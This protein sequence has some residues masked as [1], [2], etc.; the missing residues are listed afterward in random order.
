MK[1]ED[2]IDRLARDATAVR[3]LPRP[4]KRALG[5]LL[6]ALV[7][8]AAIAGVA[9]RRHS[10]LAATAEPVYILQQTALFVTGLTAAVAAFVSVVPGTSRRVVAAPLVPGLVLAVS[11]VWGCV[12]DLRQHGTLGVASQTDWPCVL[13]MTLG[14]AFLWTILSA[15]LRRGASLAPGLTGTFAGAAALSMTNVEACLTRPHA[16]VSVVVV[17]HGLTSLAMIAALAMA[18]RYVFGWQPATKGLSQ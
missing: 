1:T 15:M 6:C 13:S 5:W 17:W 10:A 4:W 11:L 8:L 9:L 3:P 18:G 14:G 12:S 2:L 7:Y 16:F